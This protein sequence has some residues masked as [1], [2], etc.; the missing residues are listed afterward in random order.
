MVK[1]TTK[2]RIREEV[3]ADQAR[4]DAVTQRLKEAIERYARLAEE[5]RK[6]E[7]S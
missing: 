2:Q 5:Q 4:Y 6:A 3:K 1:K 7:S